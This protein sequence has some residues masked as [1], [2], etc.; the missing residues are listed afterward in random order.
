MIQK[1]NNQ[2]AVEYKQRI[3]NVVEGRRVLLPANYKRDYSFY[4]GSEGWGLCINQPYLTRVTPK[5]HPPLS[6][7]DALKFYM[8]DAFEKG[9][10][11]RSERIFVD[12]IGLQ[13]D[14]YIPNKYLRELKA[15]HK[16]IEGFIPEWWWIDQNKAY[17]YSTERTQSEIVALFWAGNLMSYT[18]WG[19]KE[20]NKMKEGKFKWNGTIYFQG[21]TYNPIDV[22]AWSM[23]YTHHELQNNW[24]YLKERIEYLK[25]CVEHKTPPSKERIE[26]RLPHDN[27]KYWLCKSANSRCKWT[28]YCPYYAKYVNGDSY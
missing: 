7:R 16:S 21:L 6:F 17:C 13:P 28:D 19:I 27:D 18:P 22:K 23:E 2:V 25:Y 12:N 1:E 11:E 4:H 14:D 10:I 5:P 8:G 3:S 15:T 20:L 9:I 26:E 24:E